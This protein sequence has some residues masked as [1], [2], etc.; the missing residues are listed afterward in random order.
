M[1]QSYAPYPPPLNSRKEPNDSLRYEEGKEDQSP[2]HR[3]T[4]AVL[5]DTSIKPSA[6]VLVLLFSLFFLSQD[7]GPKSRLDGCSCHIVSW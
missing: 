2:S 6:R 7:P 5:A 3:L 1:E 4:T